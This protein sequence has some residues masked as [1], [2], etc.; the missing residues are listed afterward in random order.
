ML[1][2]PPPFRDRIQLTSPDG[3]FGGRVLGWSA[4]FRSLC[5]GG[6]I[7]SWILGVSGDTRHMAPT[8]SFMFIYVSSIRFSREHIHICTTGP[9]HRVFVFT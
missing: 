9:L 2:T 5:R 7:L 8:V 4:C 3:L 6:F 1:L